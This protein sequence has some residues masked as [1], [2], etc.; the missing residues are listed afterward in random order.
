M[1]ALLVV[2]LALLLPG[3]SLSAEPMCTAQ[4]G[5]IVPWVVELYTSEGCSSCLPSDRWLSSVKDRRELM[6]L[7]SVGNGELRFTPQAPTTPSVL[8]CHGMLVITDARTGLPIQ[9]LAAGC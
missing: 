6:S 3:A 2:V 5:A 8:P 7:A 9:A 1:R 4:S